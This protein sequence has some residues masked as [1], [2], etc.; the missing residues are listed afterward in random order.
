MTLED[1]Q[2]LFETATIQELQQNLTT[3]IIFGY[4]RVQLD[5]IPAHLFE[6]PQDWQL[7]LGTVD[8]YRRTHHITFKQKY[9]L[10]HALQRHSNQIQVW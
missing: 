1:L 4:A 6:S 9:S 5:Q 3:K 7:M 2:Y 10:L 8:Q